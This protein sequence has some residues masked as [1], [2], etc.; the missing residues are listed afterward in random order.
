MA[1]CGHLHGHGHPTAAGAAARIVDPRRRYSPRRR[2]SLLPTAERFAGGR[3]LRSIRGRQGAD[4][5]DTTTLGRTVAEAGEQIATVWP[6]KSLRE[7]SY[8]CHGLLGHRRPQVAPVQRF[9]ALLQEQANFQ[10]V[11]SELYFLWLQ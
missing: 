7:N 8:F 6:L 2:A 1:G 3:R 5:G 10:K 11:P 9:S 4:Q